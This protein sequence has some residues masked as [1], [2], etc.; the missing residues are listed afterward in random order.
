MWRQ[1]S[2]SPIHGTPHDQP[3]CFRNTIKVNCA[4]YHTTEGEVSHA[5]VFC[6]PSIPTLSRASAPVLLSKLPLIHTRGFE[7][8]SSPLL[9]SYQ[10]LFIF[11]S[12]RP[13]FGA[14]QQHWHRFG[15]K[16]SLTTGRSSLALSSR[17]H[18]REVLAVFLV[19]CCPMFFHLM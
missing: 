12:W 19:I 11:A 10:V 1:T 17:S 4:S 5:A 16:P 13:F 3:C 18:T 8:S 15:S 2:Q 6:L 14:A 7:P 9:I